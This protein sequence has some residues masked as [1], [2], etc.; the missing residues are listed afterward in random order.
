M[1]ARAILSPPAQECRARP[2]PPRQVTGS[3][4]RWDRTAERVRLAVL[5]LPRSCRSEASQPTLCSKNR[6]FTPIRSSSQDPDIRFTASAP[7]LKSLVSPP[8]PPPLP[9]ARAADR[10]PEGSAQGP[11]A[12]PPPPTPCVAP[13]VQPSALLSCFC[14]IAQSQNSMKR[15][16][17]PLFLRPTKQYAITNQ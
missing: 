6:I 9:F 5:G 16:C 11:A 2:C 15:I 7:H 8:L 17:P 10:V 4:F 14:L 12:P 3:H 1:Q 13:S